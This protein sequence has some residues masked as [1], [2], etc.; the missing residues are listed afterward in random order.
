MIKDAEIDT[1]SL[2]ELLSQ[3]ELGLLSVK[4]EN[5]LQ[6]HLTKIKTE[7]ESLREYEI[8]DELTEEQ[9]AKKIKLEEL[10]AKIEGNESKDLSISEAETDFE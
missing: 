8:A 9:K 6:Y 4:K 7:L 3:R 2:E 5:L 10:V 1:D